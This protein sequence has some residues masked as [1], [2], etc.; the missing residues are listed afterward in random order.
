MIWSLKL[1]LN[2]RDVSDKL[3]KGYIYIFVKYHGSLITHPMGNV[4]QSISF[5]II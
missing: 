5:I 3:S 4:L 2:Y 1:N